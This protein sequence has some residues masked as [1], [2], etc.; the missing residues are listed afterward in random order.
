[1][2]RE[3]LSGADTFV[4]KFILPP[5]LLLGAELLA[6]MAYVPQV[7]PDWMP[8]LPHLGWV[9]P[10]AEQPLP[11]VLFWG[12]VACLVFVAW[13]Y[14]IVIKRVE[15]DWAQLYIS[16]YRREFAVSIASV[17][18]VRENPVFSIDPPAIVLDE[19]TPWGRV[20]R[21]SPPAL[22]SPQMWG[23][24]PLFRMRT[25]PHPLL[26]ELRTISHTARMGRGLVRIHQA[27]NGLG[28]HTRR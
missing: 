15:T 27:A 26:E 8:R 4:S 6:V 7:L 9:P 21:F 16:D 3:R 17:V 22:D 11:H 5:V 1:M 14:G 12:I 10:V 19:D 28:R 13:W 20:I 2:R 25:Y 23:R 24:V 18:T